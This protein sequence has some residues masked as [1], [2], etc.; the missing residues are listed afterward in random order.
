MF[1][2]LSALFL[3]F[4]LLIILSGCDYLP[5]FKSKPQKPT[6]GSVPP[7][8]VIVAAKVGNFYAT[9]DD[10]NK[11][12]EAYNALVNAQGMAQNK[13]DTRDKKIAYL[14]NEMV[15]KYILYQEALDRGLDK[16]EAVVRTLE[17]AKISLLVAELLREETEKVNVASKEIEDFYNQN[18]ELLR[19]PEQRRI[20]EIVTAS[21]SEAKQAY[22]ELLKGGDFASLAKQYSKA[23]SATNGGDLSFIALEPDPK[24]RIRFDK[25]YEVAFAPTLEV[26]GISSIFKGPDGYYMVKLE[27]IKKP[28]TKSVSEL[29]ENIKQWLLFEKQQKAIADLA[30]K[31]SGE[32]KIEVYEGKVE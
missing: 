28:E 10:L 13:I 7:P 17:N 4:L 12:V 8:G 24:K 3:I 5:F 11:E 18:K 22:I 20:F 19:E 32:T 15:R 26:G 30:N 25:F 23:T 27:S 21:E 16:K 14:R 31:L 29:W 1:K 9:Q 2:K 6:A